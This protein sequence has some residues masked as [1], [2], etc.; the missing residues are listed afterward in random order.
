MGVVNIFYY[1]LKYFTITLRKKIKKSWGN[2]HVLIIKK[3]FRRLHKVAQSIFA[4]E[5]LARFPLFPLFLFTLKKKENITYTE[6]HYKEQ[7]FLLLRIIVHYHMSFHVREREYWYW[8]G[9]IV[10]STSYLISCACS[11]IKKSFDLYKFRTN[12]INRR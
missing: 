8:Y 1:L 7:I 12:L 10:L 3:H 4:A 2:R 9:Y 5:L 6:F 11:F